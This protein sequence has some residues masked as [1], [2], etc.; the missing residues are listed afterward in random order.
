MPR[1][2]RFDGET[3]E[4]FCERADRAGRYA[5]FLVEACLAN[6]CVQQYIADPNDR[7]GKFWLRRGAKV[8]DLDRIGKNLGVSAPKGGWTKRSTQGKI[9]GKTAQI[10]FRK[11][12]QIRFGRFLKFLSTSGVAKIGLG[13]GILTLARKGYDLSQGEGTREFN[14]LMTAYRS[15]MEFKLLYGYP[16]ENKLALVIDAFDRYMS[17]LDVSGTVRGVINVKM[18]VELSKYH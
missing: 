13:F 9:F 3:D 10:G 1:R 17:V 11:G 16:S 2:L 7:W 15:S 5:K 6:G 8:A 14:D 18:R 4:Q 12:R